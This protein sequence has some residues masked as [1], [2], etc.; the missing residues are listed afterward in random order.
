MGLPMPTDFG[1]FSKQRPCLS[2]CYSKTISTAPGQL[3]I[4]YVAH[5]RGEGFARLEQ[6]CKEAHDLS[7]VRPC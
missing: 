6:A 5:D 3:G 7:F 1:L 4:I 2:G